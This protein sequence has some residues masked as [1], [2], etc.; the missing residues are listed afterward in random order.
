MNLKELVIE[1]DNTYGL[2]L[3]PREWGYQAVAYWR[4]PAPAGY[5]RIAAINKALEREK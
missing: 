2:L 4:T 5:D 1:S 3:R